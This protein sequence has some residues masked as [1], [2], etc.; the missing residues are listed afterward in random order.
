VLGPDGP[1]CGGF[2]CPATVAQAERW[3][4][5]QLAP[6]D[7]LR[8]VPIASTTATQLRRRV[9]VV[10]AS[11]RGDRHAPRLVGT[12][13]R[14]GGILDAHEQPGRPLCTYRRAGD[15]FLLVEYGEMVLDLELRARV[16]VLE[17]ALHARAVEPII[18]M[19]AGVRS[20]LIQFNASAI[21][22]AELIELVREV[23]AELPA[24]D[25]LEVP[26]RIVHLPLS[27]EDPA[28][29][30]AIQRY[31]DVVRDDAPWCPS[32]LEFIR[33]INGIDSIDAVRQIV[34]AASYLVLGL[35]DVYLGAPVATPIDPRHRLV[36]TKYNPARTWT[37]E[38][39]VGIGGAYLCIYGMEGPGGYQFI[40]RTV[41]VWYLGVDTPGED[42]ATP[43]LLRN[44]DQ[45][46]FFPVE[47]GDL[48]ELRAEAK[49]GCLD[50]EIEP[51]TFRLAEH[52]AFLN[53]N[54]SSIDEFRAVQ[55]AAFEAE[56]QR[57]IE[58]GEIDGDR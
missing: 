44:F 56:R 19:T 57:W 7:E 58:C 32:N 43:W 29:L 40:G 50:L 55:R 54:A 24:A 33:R 5:G 13:V 48:V 30:E 23:D 1:S 27:W 17:R 36:T 9:S 46:R 6:G 4:L 52:R 42:P 49:A 47:A 51:T 34:F 39:S 10:T 37:A 28:T 12:S 35:G 18:D 11:L 22:H 3:K 2:T 20:L 14:D 41:P 16:H 38:N 53:A 8:F 31:M 15:D 21:D 26:G 25:E 45:L